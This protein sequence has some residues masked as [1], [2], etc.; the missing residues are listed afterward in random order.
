MILTTTTI[1]CDVCKKPDAKPRGDRQNFQVIF[2][3]DQT[4][5]RSREPYLSMER[6]DLCD[7]CY[8]KVLDGNG[9]F[10]SGAQ[11]HNQYWFKRP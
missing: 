5:G 6:V 3:T 1:F 7:E 9:L 8:A 11:G 10:G 4:E 2:T